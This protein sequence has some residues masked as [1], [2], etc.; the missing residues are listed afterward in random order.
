MRRKPIL[1]LE[2]SFLGCSRAHIIKRCHQL[3]VERDFLKEELRV[4]ARY[5][6]AVSYSLEDAQD[7]L[8]EEREGRDDTVK[9]LQLQNDRLNNIVIEVI[10]HLLSLKLKSQDQIVK[11]LVDRFGELG[12]AAKP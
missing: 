4:S 5:V 7:R 1:A 12:L 2:E 8:K 6:G 10:E 9:E 3:A 11:D